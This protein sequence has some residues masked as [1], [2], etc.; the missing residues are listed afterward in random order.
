MKRF[1]SGLTAI[2]L[3]FTF[4]V[5]HA[6]ATVEEC[7]ATMKSFKDLGNVSEML[8]QSYGY[9]VLPTIGKAGI[10]IGGAGGTG[11]VFE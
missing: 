5:A 9:A 2:L 6:A 10:G 3:T 4:S 11:C 8:A 7:N 1:L